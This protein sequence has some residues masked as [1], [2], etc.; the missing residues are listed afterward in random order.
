MDMTIKLHQK[1]GTKENPGMALIDVTVELIRMPTSDGQSQP[2]QV[3]IRLLQEQV[4]KGIILS[5]DEWKSVVVEV[6]Q[7]ME[8]VKTVAEAAP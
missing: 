3:Q 2:D 8:E 4:T 7:M 1:L 5:E 6:N